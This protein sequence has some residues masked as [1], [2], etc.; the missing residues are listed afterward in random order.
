MDGDMI[1]MA[2]YT[3]FWTKFE[4][5]SIRQAPYLQKYWVFRSFQTWFSGDKVSARFSGDIWKMVSMDGDMISMAKYTWF[6]T[7]FEK[8]SIWQA[9]D[10]Q[11]YE[12]S[13]HLKPDSRVM[14]SVLDLLVIFWKR[15]LWMAM[16]PWQSTLGFEPNSR[17][18]PYD[19]HLIAR[20]MSFQIR[21]N[22]IFGW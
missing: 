16:Y 22:L 17:R 4:K 6:W 21:L 8:E 1:S 9:Q 14:R 3:W 10:I 18:N 5:E 12:F 19:K 7:K 11:I 15:F 2:K 20:N 13:G